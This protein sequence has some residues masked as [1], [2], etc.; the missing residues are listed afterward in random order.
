MLAAAF[1]GP[2]PYLKPDLRCGNYEARPRVCRIY[3]AEITPH[4]AL[5]PAAKS[6]STETSAR[7]RR[8]FVR[9]GNLF[10]LETRALIE[11]HRAASIDD[12]P[13]KARACFELGIARASQAMPSMRRPLPA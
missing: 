4:L 8:P 12:V 13:L 11:E 6:C 10:D 3:P 7:D 5:D 2:C 9:G 1:D